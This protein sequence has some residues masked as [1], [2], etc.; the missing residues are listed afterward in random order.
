MLHDTYI[1]VSIGTIFNVRVKGYAWLLTSGTFRYLESPSNP[2]NMA[3]PFLG[4]LQM[5]PLFKGH[6]SRNLLGWF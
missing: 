5:T 4:L 3:A 1:H 6:D 2:S